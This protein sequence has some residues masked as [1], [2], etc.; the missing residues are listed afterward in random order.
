MMVPFHVIIC[1]M[2]QLSQD[3]KH[4]SEHHLAWR[5]V[6]DSFNVLKRWFQ[7]ISLQMTVYIYNFSVSLSISLYISFEHLSFSSSV[8]SFSLTFQGL[9]KTKH[10]LNLEHHLPIFIFLS[11]S[12]LSVSVTVTIIKII[13][14]IICVTVTITIYQ[15]H[16]W[17]CP[18]WELSCR[19]TSPSLWFPARPRPSPS[20]HW[21]DDMRI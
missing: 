13:I 7:S 12:T 10:F 2:I 17:G 9:V 1:L 3:G 8:L 4:L 19:R 21:W 6:A 5:F 15:P 14:K 16:A 11:S 20:C 18:Q